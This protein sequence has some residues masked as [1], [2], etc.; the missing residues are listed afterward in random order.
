MRDWDA[1]HLAAAAGASVVR[2]P[3]AAPMRSAEQAGGPGRP[4]PVGVSIDSRALQPGEL[5]VGLRGERT[6]GGVHAAQA[7]SAGAWGVLVTGEHA[8]EALAAS[9]AAQPPGALGAVLAHDDPLAG[10]QKL[11]RAWRRELRARGAMV[12]AITGSTGKTSTKDI[13]AALLAPRLRVTASPANLNTEIGMPLALLGAPADTELVVLEMAMRGPGQIAELTAIAEPDV[14][15]IVNVG[16]AHLELLGSLEAIAAAK[17]EL[18][19]GLA[20]GASVVVPANEPLLAPHLRP[21]LRTISFGEGGA[22]GLREH[23]ADGT[24]VIDDD[25][26]RIELQPSFTQAYNLR[27]LLAAT[28]AARALGYTPRGRV[29]V[30]FSALRGQREELRGGVVLVADCYNANPMSMRA[31]ID[32]LAETADARRVAVLGD[33]LELGPDAPLM[34]AEIGAHAQA[35]GVELLVTVGALAGEMRTRFAGESYAVADAQAA[36]ELVPG[37]LREGDTVLVKGSRGVGLERL[38]ERV[39]EEMAPAVAP[40]VGVASEPR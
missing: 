33:M 17:A 2:P 38:L 12:V 1:R 14:G 39:R 27:N 32:D 40:G 5:F 3:A 31:A 28:A 34:H 25:G 22:V 36:A 35:R 15:V 37:L 26:E 30:R 19:A 21:E 20:P 18:I 16:P 11:A 4:G 24:V 10:L 9:A 29:D 13:L 23:R 7:L 8:R 6:D